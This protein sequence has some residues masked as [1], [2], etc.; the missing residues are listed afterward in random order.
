MNDQEI[1]NEGDEELAAVG[2]SGL[3]RLS[4][5]LGGKS[6]LPVAFTLIPQMLLSPQWEHRSATSHNNTRH[7]LA[8]LPSHYVIISFLGY[9]ISCNGFIYFC[10]RFAALVAVASL[11]VC[12][13]LIAPEV[14]KVSNNKR[15]TMLF[16]KLLISALMLCRSSPW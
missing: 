2:A 16:L 14:P 7:T 1:I 9:S 12:G 8:T 10:N 11:A 6:I 4:Q 5:A 13:K 3:S 15:L